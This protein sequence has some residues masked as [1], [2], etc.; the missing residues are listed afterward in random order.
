M[1][2]LI[3][4]ELKFDNIELC[5]YPNTKYYYCFFL[6]LSIFSLFVLLNE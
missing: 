4:Y 1:L 6:F 5:I 2:S 3:K